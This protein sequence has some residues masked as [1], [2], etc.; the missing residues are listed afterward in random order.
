[1]LRMRTTQNSYL[2]TNGFSSSEIKNKRFVVKETQ[3][4]EIFDFVFALA[5]WNKRITKLVVLAVMFWR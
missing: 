1:M 4:Q 5:T 3:H 2:H